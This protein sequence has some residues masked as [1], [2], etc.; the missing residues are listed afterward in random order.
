MWK[1]TIFW[2]EKRKVEKFWTSFCQKSQPFS[3]QVPKSNHIQNI[4]IIII[5][6]ISIILF[7]LFFDT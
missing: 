3:S 1:G 5:I 2:R 4:I 6:I 7:Y